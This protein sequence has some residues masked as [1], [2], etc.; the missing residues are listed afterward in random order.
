MI[1]GCGNRMACSG[2]TADDVVT[3]AARR[4]WAKCKECGRELV[5]HTG[6]SD[7]V[8]FLRAA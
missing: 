5:F 1:T 7:N 2:L 6:V 3:E 8:I 4:S